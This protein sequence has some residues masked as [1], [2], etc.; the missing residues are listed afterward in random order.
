MTAVTHDAAD[1]AEFGIDVDEL[2]ASLRDPVMHSMELLNEISERYP[3]AISFAAD[4]PTEEFF[5]SDDIEQYLAAYRRYAVEQTGQRPDQIRRTL[6]QYGRTKGVI[7]E[8]LARH[9]LVD[10]NVEAD[11]EAIVVTA[12][13]QEAMLL[14]IRTLCADPR[15]VMLAA[16][17]FYVGFAGAAALLD[18]PVLPVRTDD[19]G[20]DL[21]DLRRQVRDARARG[22]RPR[23]CYLIPDFSNPAGTRLGLEARLDLIALAQSEDLLLIE[24]NPY[25]QF[26]STARLPT[27]KSL[28]RSRHVVYLGSLAKTAMPSARVGY[29]LADQRVWR[30]GEPD[31]L[32]ADKLSMVKSMVTVNTSAIAQAVVAGKPILHDFS[33]SAALGAENQRYADNRE[34]MLHGLSARFSGDAFAPVSWNAPTGGFFVV[35]TMP[36]D[37]DDDLL[38]RS[39]A[40]FGISWVPMYHFYAGGGGHRQLRFS[41]SAVTAAQIDEGLDRFA[42]LVRARVAEQ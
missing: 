35:L 33:L 30:A 13:C 22:L 24:D 2:H 32:L 36:F 37:V 34:L 12:G 15:D 17:P 27:L 6:F 38:R 7:H 26:G 3:Q 1:R 25:G 23:G 29:V 28:D 42:A 18:V 4:R 21:D 41:W 19:D 10:E 14:V 8:I 9:L 5:D 11:P 39:A 16:S 31:G 40:E 20:I